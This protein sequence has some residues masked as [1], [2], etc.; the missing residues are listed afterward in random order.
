[1]KLSSQEEYGLRCL[2]HVAR[3]EGS[4]TITIPQISERE[5]ISTFYAAKLLRLL[6]RTGFLKSARGAVGGYELARPADQIYVSEVLAALGGRLFD[7]SFCEQHA[8]HE[9]TCS[10]SVDCSVRTL[11]RTVQIVV[12][13]VLSKVTLKDLEAHDERQMLPFVCRLVNISPQNLAVLEKRVT[14]GRN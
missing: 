1:M 5:G 6:R 12:D 10:H 7:D 13:Q 9:A 11:W 8:G 2:L 4:G 3:L 14:A